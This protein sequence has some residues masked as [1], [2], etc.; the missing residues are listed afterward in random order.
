MLGIDLCDRACET[1]LDG[2]DAG[3]VREVAGVICGGRSG[4][5]RGEEAKI[6]SIDGE[7]LGVQR[8][9]ELLPNTEAGG[10]ARRRGGD[11]G[12]CRQEAEKWEEDL[13]E[14]ERMGFYEHLHDRRYQS[15]RL[16]GTVR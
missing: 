11:A 12:Q 2:G 4:K 5:D 8:L 10:G 9:V 16:V 15:L 13:G 3:E 6:L 14:G 7:R 1:S